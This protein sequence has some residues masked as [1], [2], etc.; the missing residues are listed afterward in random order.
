MAAACGQLR[1]RLDEGRFHRVFAAARDQKKV[2]VTILGRCWQKR[3][4]P[5]DATCL[6]YRT[7]HSVSGRDHHRRF[8]QA[9]DPGRRR[10]PRSKD[11]PRVHL[12]SRPD[13]PAGQVHAHVQTRPIP[14]THSAPAS[15]A[16]RCV[17]GALPF[18]R[19]HLSSSVT[20]TLPADWQNFSGVDLEKYRQPLW[21]VFPFLNADP[22]FRSKELNRSQDLLAKVTSRSDPNRGGGS[23]EGYF[24]PFPPPESSAKVALKRS[25]DDSDL[26]PHR[27]NNSAVRGFPTMIMGRQSLYR[28]FLPDYDN[29][30]EIEGHHLAALPGRE[31]LMV[32]QWWILMPDE[33]ML[34]PPPLPSSPLLIPPNAHN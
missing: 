1:S 19:C 5:V 25:Y 26:F 3:A 15:A 28:F 24:P 9:A 31:Q 27:L 21:I 18:C 4:L 22:A 32:D 2:V 6:V 7:Q 23:G 11:G 8:D 34:P 12:A 16:E 30:S 20:S 17:V 13:V 33:S 14:G 10:R 29:E